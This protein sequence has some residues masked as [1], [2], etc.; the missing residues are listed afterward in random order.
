MI[1]IDKPGASCSFTEK[2]L[3]R[4]R[5]DFQKN[6]FVRLPDLIHKVLL[7]EIYS[8][9]VTADWQEKIHDG[10]GTEVCLNDP[11]TVSL[12]NFLFNDQDLF[13]II[14]TIT[15]CEPIGCF[16]G[17]VYRMIP[18]SG[19]YDSWH[20]DFGEDR[21]LALSL[22]LGKESYEGG[23]LQIR[24]DGVIN[25]LIEAPNP[26]FGDAVLFQISR[27]LRHRV[28]NVEGNVPKTAFAGWFKSSPDLW[29]TLT[30]LS[31]SNQTQPAP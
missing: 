1:T 17:R 16:Q 7:E 14:Q 25:S 18:N 24:H 11:G 23:L 28:T 12:I 13:K 30:E 21:L 15:A 9:I 27:E 5:H 6:H 22:N 31:Q 8:Q 26:H 20:T 4:V 10:I 29:A 2:E 3:S 19:H